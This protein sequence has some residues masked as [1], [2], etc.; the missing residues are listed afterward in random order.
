MRFARRRLAQL[1]GTLEIVSAQR[2]CRSIVQGV[3]DEHLGDPRF[4]SEGLDAFG[5][6][7]MVRTVHIATA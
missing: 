4:A 7:C 6:A 1:P 3:S 5:E 2:Q